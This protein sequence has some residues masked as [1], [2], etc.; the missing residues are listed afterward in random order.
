M[1]SGAGTAVLEKMLEDSRNYDAKIVYC[2]TGSNSMSS[3]LKK[4]GFVELDVC[5]FYKLLK[6]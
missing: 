2:P 4:N 1:R 6:G 5:R 3:L